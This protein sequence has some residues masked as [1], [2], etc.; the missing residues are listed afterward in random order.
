MQ[1]TDDDHRD[2]G[3]ELANVAQDFYAGFFFAGL[4]R[5][6]NDVQLLGADYGKNLPRKR[7]GVHFAAMAKQDR[8]QHLALDGIVFNHQNL[9]VF[10]NWVGHAI[11]GVDYY[12]ESGVESIIKSLGMR[13]RIAWS[14]CSR[15]YTQKSQGPR[16]NGFEN[17][18][19]S[20]RCR[21]PIP[22]KPI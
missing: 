14:K 9:W 1:F 18:M 19:V 17:C 11:Y 7:D 4:D 10:N 3:R 22:P 15:R 13:S 12:L 6:N 21:T 8:L 2:S 5:Q 20:A 16:V